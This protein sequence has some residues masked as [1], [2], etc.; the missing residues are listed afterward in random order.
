MIKRLL[1]NLLGLKSNP[2][3]PLLL[4]NGIP[5]IGKNVYIGAF[6]E[7]NA[8]G[9]SV[10]IGDNCDIASFCSLNVADSHK[11]TIGVTNTIE[12]GQIVLE[13]NVFI[14][15][16]SFIGGRVKIG[17]NSVIAAHTCLI[18]DGLII[19]PYSLVVG[20]PYVVKEGYYLDKLN[21]NITEDII[22][23]QDYLKSVV[24]KPPTLFVSKTDLDKYQFT[25]EEIANWFGVSIEVL[26]ER[27]NIDAPPPG[28]SRED[29]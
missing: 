8:K 26:P 9:G 19:P 3:H 10:I 14:G 7:I 21:G 16:H 12:R 20:N 28:R 15:S 18:A 23:A 27:K 13:D 6:S 17:H 29:F 4:Y 2:F 1:I 25:E 11:K 22:K 24:K 5:D